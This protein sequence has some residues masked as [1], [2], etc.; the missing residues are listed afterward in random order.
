MSVRS[1]VVL[2]VQ[3]N[4]LLLSPMI[5]CTG[6][7]IFQSHL[8]GACRGFASYDL[9]VVL[10]VVWFSRVFV[11]FV[12][13]VVQSGSILCFFA[14]GRLGRKTIASRLFDGIGHTTVYFASIFLAAR[15]RYLTCCVKSSRTLWLLF[16][17]YCVVV[18]VSF[19]LFP[20]SFSRLRP[21]NISIFRGFS[22][23]L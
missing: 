22:P 9:S 18:C 8:S 14:F 4:S 6:V 16:F 23:I 7:F 21:T 2:G 19:Q 3:I 10:L 17:N 1:G 5:S 20:T 15:L 13:L 12:A 11:S